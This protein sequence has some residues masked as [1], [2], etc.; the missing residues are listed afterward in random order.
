MKLNKLLLACLL[1]NLS[2]MLIGC[3]TVPKAPSLEDQKAKLFTPDPGKASIYIYREMMLKGSIGNFEITVDGRKIGD[4]AVGTYFWIQV[5]PG[6]HD[7]WA[8]AWETNSVTVEAKAGQSYFISVHVSSAFASAKNIIEVVD[9]AEGKKSVKDCSLL[10]T[11]Y[12]G[13]TL[14]Q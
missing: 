7:V 12:K 10:D 5:D 6:A 14:Y 9:A 4:L 8:K 11:T 1:Y 3:S 2:L 13:P